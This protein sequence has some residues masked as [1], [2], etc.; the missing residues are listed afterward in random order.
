LLFSVCSFLFSV[1]S[2]TGFAGLWRIWKPAMN[3]SMLRA[4]RVTEAASRTKNDK[5]IPVCMAGDQHRP[6]NKKPI[7]ALARRADGMAL[8]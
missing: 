6:K 2:G 4:W 3:S 7:P 1:G 8:S 5:Q